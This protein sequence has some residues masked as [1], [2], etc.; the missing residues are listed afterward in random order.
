MQRDPYEL[1]TVEVRRSSLTG[2]QDG[3]FTLRHVAAG[4]PGPMGEVAGH[5]TPDTRTRDST[6]TRTRDSRH[7]DT[8]QQAPGHV[9]AVNRTRDS[10]QQVT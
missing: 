10:R 1:Q 8:W 9:T 3:L 4:I 2:A 5:V 7:Q 6:V